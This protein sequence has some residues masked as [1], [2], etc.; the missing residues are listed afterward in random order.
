MRLKSWGFRLGH[1]NGIFS[2][3][4][5]R[6]NASCF[7]G[8][9]TASMRAINFAPTRLPCSRKRSFWNVWSLCVMCLL[10]NDSISWHR[11]K[12]VKIAKAEKDFFVV[13]LAFLLTFLCLS[14]HKS[15]EIRLCPHGS[16]RHRTQYHKS[17]LRVLSFAF[18]RVQSRLWSC[19]F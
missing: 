19:N 3:Q 13:V 11:R 10:I 7:Y 4:A 9:L 18:H 15:K 6:F 5:W 8:D 2:P 14:D 1:F 17:I 16:P 12:L